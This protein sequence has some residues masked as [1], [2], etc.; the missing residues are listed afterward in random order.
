MKMNEYGEI[1]NCEDNFKEIAL[2]LIQYKSVLIQW[3]DEE[4]TTYTVLFSTNVKKYESN[5]LRWG[6]NHKDNDLFVSIVGIKSRPFAFPLLDYLDNGYIE[7]KIN[8]Y[9]EKLFELIKNVIFYLKNYT[10]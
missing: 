7:G 10:N 6:I 8:I 3:I 9:N 2:D 5:E 1:Y 4:G